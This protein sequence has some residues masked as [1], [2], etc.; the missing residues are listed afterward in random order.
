V[1]YRNL[2]IELRD[3]GQLHIKDIADPLDLWL[4]TRR[5]FSE[6]RKVLTGAYGWTYP[7][8]T[9]GDVRQLVKVWDGVHA[10]LWRSDLARAGQFRAQWKEAKSAVDVATAGAD[11]AAPFAENERFWLRW[12]KRQGIY[13]ST[14]RDAPSKWE[15]VVDS[16]KTSISQLPENLKTGAAA[17]ADTGASVAGKA[18]QVVAAPVRGVFSGLFGKLGTPLLIGATVVAGIV[19]V[20]RLL[21]QR[22][23]ATPPGGSS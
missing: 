18:G 6:K 1:T 9:N 22:P 5:F 21:P 19:V 3:N 2:A 10:K 17:I 7:E 14:V 4:A 15:M 16:V 23:A 8:T 13:L 12:T 11:P 20:P